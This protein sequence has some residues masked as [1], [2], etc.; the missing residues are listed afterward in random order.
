MDQMDPKVEST[1]P[2]APAELME[3]VGSKVDPKVDPVD[4]VDPF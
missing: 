2:V 1:K 4:P 3:L